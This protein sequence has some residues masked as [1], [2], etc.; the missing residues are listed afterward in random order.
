MIAHE[1]KW[2]LQQGPTSPEYRISTYAST[3]AP[4]L[5]LVPGYLRYP[6][7]MIKHC[8]TKGTASVTMACVANDMCCDCFCQIITEAAEQ[9]PMTSADNFMHLLN[10][11]A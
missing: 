10:L 7:Y 9:L 1:V 6:L 3:S 2:A 4:G 11:I 5:G 8:H